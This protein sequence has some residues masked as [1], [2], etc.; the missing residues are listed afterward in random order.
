MP[1][2]GATA[3]SSRAS[4]SSARRSRRRRGWIS[5]RTQPGASCASPTRGASASSRRPPRKSSALLLRLLPEDLEA[6]LLGEHLARVLRGRLVERAGVHL[7]RGLGVAE[8][9]LVLA[10]DLRADRDVDVRVEQRL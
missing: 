8:A 5:A 9:P 3:G 4:C 2:A 1:T 10:Q 6:R 7:Q